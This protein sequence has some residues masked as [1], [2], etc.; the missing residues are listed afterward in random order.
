MEP[1]TILSLI[2]STLLLIERCFKYYIKNV[3]KSS[4]CGTN[5]EFEHEKT[6]L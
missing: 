1:I 6:D 5:V 3:K 4:C 2:M